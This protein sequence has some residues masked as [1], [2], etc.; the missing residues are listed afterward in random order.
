MTPNLL[1]KLVPQEISTHMIIT[2]PLLFAIQIMIEEVMT[3]LNLIVAIAVI[4]RGESI[5]EM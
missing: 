2:D 3:S 5:A 4:L 1:E